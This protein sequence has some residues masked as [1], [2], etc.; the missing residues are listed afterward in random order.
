MSSKIKYTA[1]PI[2]KL[3]VIPDFLPSPGELAFRDEGVKVTLTMSK[4]SMDFFKSQAST[5]RTQ[6]QR[7]IRR[8]L[9]AYVDSQQT[10]A[11]SGQRK[12]LPR[13]LNQVEAGESITITRNGK[14]VARLSPVSSAS[15]ADAARRILELRK[16][17]AKQA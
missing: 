6:Y 15:T 4:K 3:L 16:K 13:L 11:S 17:V 12:N 1:E 9:D 8:L 5:H 2:G 14:P 10:Q 7:M